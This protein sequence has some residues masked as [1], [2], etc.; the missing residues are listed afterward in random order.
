LAGLCLLMLPSLINTSSNMVTHVV[1]PPAIGTNMLN[2]ECIVDEGALNGPYER[3]WFFTEGCDADRSTIVELLSD[4]WWVERKCEE[5][6]DDVQKE[7]YCA[8]LDESAMLQGLPN[9]V[10][11]SCGEVYSC[12]LVQC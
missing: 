6:C 4:S 7:D 1:V 12:D 9:N 11:V 2:G 8:S 3:P 5:A 10:S